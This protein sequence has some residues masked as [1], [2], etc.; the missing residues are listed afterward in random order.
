MT[1]TEAVLHTGGPEDL[2]DCS[3][4]LTRLTRL[5]A[6]GLVRLQQTGDHVTLWAQPL[7]VVVRR[8]VRARMTVDDRTFLSVQLLAAVDCAAD[9]AV[10]LPAPR[11]ESWRVTL[12]PLAGWSALDAVPV[13]VVRHLA[14]GAGRVVR[15]ARDPAAAGESL[16][17]REALRVAHGADEV[18]L[19]VR[20]VVVLARMGFLGG[21]EHSED[22]VR[23]ACTPAW[24]RVAAR[25]GTAYQRRGGLGRLSLA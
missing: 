24:T 1:T 4:L 19:P 5:D 12:P 8:Q 17:D 3:T 16:L 14:V 10:Q 23:V 21:Y 18:T 15:G 7:G 2:T 22:A 25:H 6:A 13:R 11:D 20:V 9:A